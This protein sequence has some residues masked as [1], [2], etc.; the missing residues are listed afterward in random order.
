MSDTEIEGSK[1]SG[2]KKIAVA[3]VVL[4]LA[5]ATYSAYSYLS[6][7]PIKK[8]LSVKVNEVIVDHAD[9]VAHGQNSSTEYILDVSVT[10]NSSSVIRI[11]PGDFYVVTSGETFKAD[12]PGYSFFTNNLLGTVNI[13]QGQTITGQ[14]YIFVPSSYTLKSVYYD[15]KNIKHSAS[16]AVKT[17]Y[18]SFVRGVTFTLGNHLVYASTSSNPV[19]VLSNTTFPVVVQLQNHDNT[20]V[21]FYSLLAVSPFTVSNSNPSFPISIQTGSSLSVTVYVN[22]PTKS[23]YGYLEISIS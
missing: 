3:I 14:I 8:A 20:S 13:S 7:I 2:R 21:S 16:T 15:Y 5:V 18:A 17:E 19:D 11:T 6:S 12:V 9:M 1:G 23:Y 22:P 4:V 10:S